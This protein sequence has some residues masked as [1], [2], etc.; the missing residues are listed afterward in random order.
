[1]A[2]V[3]AGLVVFIAVRSRERRRRTLFDPGIGA[4][5]T[6]RAMMHGIEAVANRVTAGTQRGSLPIS[7]GAIVLVLVAFP[8]PVLGRSGLRPGKFVM[9]ASPAQAVVSIVVIALAI[10]VF[11]AGH[12]LAAVLIVGGIGYAVAVL[13]ILRGAPDLALTQVLMETVTL[14]A[15]LLVIV[16]MP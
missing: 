14:I 9:A 2:S 1:G 7:L 8:G 10:A 15:A 13:Y 4:G 6:Y 5:V 11:R 3:A 16:R 12:A